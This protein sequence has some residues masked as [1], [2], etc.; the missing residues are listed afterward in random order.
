MRT[1]LLPLLLLLLMG[2][3]FYGL[4]ILGA[5]RDFTEIQGVRY[6][7]SPV[8]NQRM[9]RFGEFDLLRLVGLSSI[10]PIYP[11]MVHVGI[12]LFIEIVQS[13]G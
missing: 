1:V 6:R 8:H 3:S 10:P 12:S 2:L 5:V 13:T 11:T 4:N 7:H 9:A